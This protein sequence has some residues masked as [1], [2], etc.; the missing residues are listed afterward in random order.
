M[1][2]LITTWFVLSSLICLL[3]NCLL[4]LVGAYH[5]AARSR[6]VKNLDRII[7]LYRHVFFFDEKITP[8]IMFVRLF[9]FRATA[10]SRVGSTTP[11]PRQPLLCPVYHLLHRILVGR[12]AQLVGDR[13]ST[14]PL[15]SV[16]SPHEVQL[17][18]N[19]KAVSLTRWYHK[20]TGPNK[21][22]TY[23]L[24]KY[25][26]DVTLQGMISDTKQCRSF[27]GM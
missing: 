13:G 6:T 4:S 7:L 5:V 17:C 12:S 11:V 16:H 20:H 1:K 19:G 21:Q 8:L 2:L 9:I 27:C 18:H 3:S 14:D 10:G 24:I 23:R 26:N 22:M 15:R 25:D